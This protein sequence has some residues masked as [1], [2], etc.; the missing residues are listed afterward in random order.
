MTEHIRDFIWGPWLM[1][2]FL[3]AGIYFTI[4]FRGFQIFRFRQ[5]WRETAGSMGRETGEE[6]KSQFA[7]ACTAL[8]ATV[9]T[10]NIAGVA[11]ALSLGGPG[12]VFWM[13]VSAAIGMMTA[14]SEVYLGQIYRYQGRDGRPICGPYAY[15]EKGLGMRGMGLIYAGLSVLASL[16]MGSMVQANSVAESAACAAGIPLP[17]TGFILTALVM[18]VIFGG[19]ERIS[20]AALRLVPFSA[21]F[22][23]GLCA[24]ILFA[25]IKQIPLALS[26]IV[27]DAFSFKSAAGGA[28]GVFLSRAVRFGV[29]RGVFS[30]EAGLGS[31]AVLHGEAEALGEGKQKKEQ[32]A[33]EQ[34]LWA[35]FEVFFDTMVSCTLT[36]LVILCVVGGRIAPGSIGGERGIQALTDL[37]GSAGVAV[38][39]SACFGKMGEVLVSA[40]MSLFAFATIIAWFYLGRQALSYMTQ[41]RKNR[42]QIFM[43]YG[44]FY[45]NAVFFGCVARLTLV[46]EL[47]DIFNG[48]MAVPNLIGLFFLRREV[49]DP[50]T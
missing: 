10:G 50:R 21:A 40:S 24:V 20:S 46:W 37:S 6:K 29:S 5:W 4:R 19:A 36:A 39:F 48:L 23:L 2:L 12:A 47:S 34:G 26:W 1:G 27:E 25:H 32:F 14:Y 22:Y 28:A 7:S 9:G 30:N 17:V 31:L 44:F 35:I 45:L 43:C 18:A 11:A 41:N 16:G 33:K 38:C 49:K 42:K 8:A 13:W 15:L 3:M